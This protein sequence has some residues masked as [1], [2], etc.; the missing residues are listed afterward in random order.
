MTIPTFPTLV[1]LE[2]PVTKQ[3]YWDTLVQ[4]PISGKETRL[5]LWNYPRY[6]YTLSF[7]VLGS[8]AQVAGTTNTDWNTLLGF[9]NQVGGSALPFHYYDSVDNSITNQ[10]LGT[11]NGT[12]TQFNFIRTLGGFIEPTQDVTQSSVQVFVT[13]FQGKLQWTDTSRTNYVEY[14]QAPQTS[15]WSLTN[16]SA[17][18]GQ[19]DPLGS[20]TAVAL[21][22]NTTNG[23]HSTAQTIQAPLPGNSVTLTL[24]AFLA[25]KTRTIAYMKVTNLAGSTF[26]AYFNLSGSGTVGTVSGSPIG[27]A[28]TQ[29]SNGYYRCSITFTSGSTGST[30][31]VITISPSVSGSDA[32]SYAGTA[33][34]GLYVWGVQLENNT[35]VGNYIATTSAQG[36]A[37]GLDLPDRQ[38][39][40]LHLRAAV[41]RR[42]DC[43][44]ADLL[45]RIIQ[46][47][48][49]VRRR[50][51][52]V[53]AVHV[54]LLVPEKGRL[55][56]HQG[57]LT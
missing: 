50:Q 18:T 53:R 30:A 9:F 16:L 52:G 25:P 56:H 19:T 7:S 31:P 49:P 42:P 15:P 34:D 40:G 17:S 2:W 47:A 36:D 48:V 1:G 43:H 4:K 23:I 44:R 10:A 39:L 33:G 12:T 27:T 26:T 29:L 57:G 46:L 32:G 11:G 8:G 51:D 37:A 6:Q 20:S 28:I 21:T 54:E 5:Q 38:Q 13:D 3:P 45:D 35:A 41:H 55:Q 14:S 24:S 22:E